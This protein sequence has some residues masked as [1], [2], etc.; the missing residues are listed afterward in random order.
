MRSNTKNYLKKLFLFLFLISFQNISFSEDG[1]NKLR[2]E[3][4]ACNLF[5]NKIENSE[6]QR[7]R[8]MF[9]YYDEDDFGFSPKATYDFDKDEW[10]WLKDGTNIIVGNVYEGDS[11]YRL[12]SGMIIEKINGKNASD[13]TDAGWYP[14]IDEVDTLKLEII[15]LDKKP[16][17][18]TIKKK[19]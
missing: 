2:D 9:L 13:I 3:R 5:Y 16:E 15:N 6:D 4:Y 8:M 7:A 11:D 18:I 14:Y 17:V 1:F 19:K 10:N 12:R